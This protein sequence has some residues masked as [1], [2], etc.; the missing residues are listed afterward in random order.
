V[1]IRKTKHI[2]LYVTLSVFAIS[3]SKGRNFEKRTVTTV[4]FV[5][6]IIQHRYEAKIIQIMELF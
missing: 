5:M 1:S 3:Y 4:Y 6:Y 2:T